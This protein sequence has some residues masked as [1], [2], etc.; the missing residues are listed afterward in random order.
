M[1]QAG[2]PRGDRPDL[3]CRD[4]V[5]HGLNWAINSAGRD[6]KVS[7]RVISRFTR[8]PQE[9]LKTTYSRLLINTHQPAAH[10]LMKRKRAAGDEYWRG[11]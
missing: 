4:E 2:P 8:Y 9:C 11:I 10:D 3:T 5:R 6:C 7:A 1:P